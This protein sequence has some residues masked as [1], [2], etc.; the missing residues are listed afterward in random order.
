MRIVTNFVFISW[1]N[2][3]WTLN[4]VTTNV[5]CKTSWNESVLNQLKWE[6]IVT[7]T[8]DLT[9]K[10]P[11]IIYSSD[12][13]YFWIWSWE[14]NC[15]SFFLNFDCQNWSQMSFKWFQV[16]ESF[17]IIKMKRA[18]C[19]SYSEIILIFEIWDSKWCSFL[20]VCYFFTKS[21]ENILSG[22]IKGGF[23]FW[24]EIHGEILI[25]LIGGEFVLNSLLL[26]ERVNNR[27]RWRYFFDIYW[28]EFCCEGMCFPWI[29]I[30]DS[31]FERTEKKDDGVDFECVFGPWKCGD[32]VESEGALCVSGGM[33][34]FGAFLFA[35]VKIGVFCT[36]E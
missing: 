2:L 1:E 17:K 25:I 35:D 23:S 3:F 24:Q 7:L 33:V 21:F 9:G 14:E 16:T 13:C 31:E 8:S 11:F 10:N 26:M 34:D 6:N 22:D 18:I 12:G 28:E 5:S 4:W 20:W 15:V 32:M 19:T 30:A 27:E 29:I 36:I